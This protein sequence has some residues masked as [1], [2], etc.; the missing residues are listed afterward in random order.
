M[1][2]TRDYDN[3]FQTLKVKHKRLLIAVINDCFQKH[4]PTD[5]PIELLSNRSFLMSK[6]GK[7]EADIEDR[8]ND[9]VLRIGEDYYLVEVQTYDDENMAIRIA[10]Y[11]FIFAR[12]IA[13]QEQDNSKKKRT[14]QGYPYQ[15]HVT[16]HIPHFTVIYIKPTERTPRYTEITYA[17]PDGREITYSEKNVFLSDMTKEEIIE[18][19]L[20][21]YIPFY[22]ARYERELST[23]KN[24]QKALEDL[25]FFRDKMV[26]LHQNKE[27]TGDELTDIGDFVN[28][29]VVHITDGNG[30]EKEAT[31]IMGGAVL[32]TKSERLRR[33]A[34]EEGLAEGREEGL[35][36]GRVEGRA[37]GR[38]EGRDIL[39]EVIRRIKH[40]EK[41]E[42]IEA[43][44]VD[45]QTVEKAMDIVQLFTT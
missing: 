40:G 45:P 33:E 20:Y 27:L 16:M 17:F 35:E 10:E 12:D 8:E 22:I 11:T 3:T 38:A 31:S 30:L 43:S 41:P 4:Y 19:K 28:T 15:R 42:S 24:Y 1:K 21:A 37:E 25:A 5:A 32:E 18:K 26:E 39:A 34:R 29:I 14:G 7:G 2:K 44:G 23:E 13:Q 36:I 6:G 9:C